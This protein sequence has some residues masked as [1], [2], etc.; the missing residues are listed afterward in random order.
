MRLLLDT[1]VFLWYVADSRELSERTREIIAKAD[2]VFVSAASIWEAAIK[3]GLGKLEAPLAD[4]VSGIS[5]S[6]FQELPV[7][8]R[9]AILVAS[10][11]QVHRDPFDRLLIAQAIDG[12]LKLL[13]ADPVFREYTE[14]AELVF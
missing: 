4:L 14:L 5:A 13:T 12:P 6:G 7:I 10:L 1:H 9:H 2:E 11:P 8:C 3:V